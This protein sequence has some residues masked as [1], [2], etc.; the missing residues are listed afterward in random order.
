VAILITGAGLIGCYLARRLL[1]RG[2]TPILYDVAPNLA[3]VRTVLDPARLAIVRGDVRDLPHL[4]QA[5][6]D[7]GVTRL[8]HTAGLI[9]PSVQQAPYTGLQINVVGTIHALEATRV[10][11]L[12]RLVF[13]ST[14]GVY[15]RAFTREGSVDEERPRGAVGLYGAS[16]AAMELIGLAY[17]DNLGVDFVALRF[18]AVF[19]PGTFVGGSII[20]EL[21]DGMV[22]GAVEGRPWR[23]RPWPLR[24]EYT[25]VEDIA[26]GVELALFAAPLAHR[27][28]N[29]GAGRTYSLQE[30][31]AT[32]QRV[33]PGADLAV[34]GEPHLAIAAAL[35]DA[36]L[37][38]TRSRAELG[39]APEYDL[40]RGLRA[41]VAAL[42]G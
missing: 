5:S 10:L 32:I 9:G 40:E 8:V 21:L 37:D 24:Q 17:T 41:Y 30:I 29:L 12:E 25:Y 6:R 14:E 31:I 20:G 19:G 11:G 35:R 4:V 39:Y 42:R 18:S 38:L 34:A 16:K 7:Q 3:F 13:A 23:V 36:P 15:D 26:R 27:V 22:R 2:E 1:D 33:V 28:Y